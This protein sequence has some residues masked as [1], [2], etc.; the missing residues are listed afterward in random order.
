MSKKDPTYDQ[1]LAEARARRIAARGQ[2]KPEPE[3]PGATYAERLEQARARRTAMKASIPVPE[4]P[5]EP[6]FEHEE[7]TG[8]GDEGEAFEFQTEGEQPATEPSA[9]QA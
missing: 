4:L 3:Q 9:E 7:A 2:P 1:R 6:D 5:T 8:E